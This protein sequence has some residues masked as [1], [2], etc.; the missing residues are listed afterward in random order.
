MFDKLKFWIRSYF[1]F[2]RTEANGFLVLAT[3]FPVVLFLP[4]LLK[5]IVDQNTA[6]V[7]VHTRQM[8]SLVSIMEKKIAA[9]KTTKKAADSR[10]KIVLTTFNP[11]DIDYQGL[12]ALGLSGGVAKRVINYREKGGKFLIKQDFKKIYGLREKQFELLKPYIDLP[13]VIAAAKEKQVPASRPPGLHKEIS[14]LFD[15]NEAD[16][17]Q[18]K[19]IYGIGSKL[20]ARII[21][22]RNRLGGFVAVEQI[23]EVYGLSEEVFKTIQKR[24]FVS[25]RFRP[26]LIDINRAD[27]ASIS[28]HPYIS[29]KM[30]MQIVKYREQHGI[31]DNLKQLMNIHIIDEQKYK[32]INPYLT[33]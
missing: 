8:D 19:S 13:D 21:K 31:F 16:T 25:D 9:V 4:A 7:I 26:E 10:Q 5:V 15:L 1:G 23:G 27:A 33:L 32:K 20:S 17:I 3:L 2:S 6:P 14:D 29:Y 11:N 28:K 12:L 18:F 24:G 30:A 22:F